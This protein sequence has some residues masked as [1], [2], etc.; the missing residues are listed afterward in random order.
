MHQQDLLYF[1]MLLSAS[2]L[3]ISTGMLKLHPPFQL[4]AVRVRPAFPHT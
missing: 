1:R 2:Q 3:G 4:H